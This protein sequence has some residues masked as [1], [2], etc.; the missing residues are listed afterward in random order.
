M[1]SELRDRICLITGGTEGVGKVTALELA[2]KGFTIV[3]KR[4]QGGGAQV[5]WQRI[6]E[7]ARRDAS[8]R[9]F[10]HECS[11]PGL[12]GGG[13]LRQ[14]EGGGPH[15]ALIELRR[16]LE[17][18]RRVSRLKLLTA[19][20]EADYLAVLGIRGHPVPGSRR[21]GWRAGLDDGMD[22]LRHRAIWL[23]HLSD[24]REHVAFPLRLVRARAAARGN[25]PL[26][27]SFFH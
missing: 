20:E 4:C 12:N 22:P 5:V 23:G 15:G 8:A 24:L 16:V 27:E 6:K 11:D 10:L 21:E 18:E 9:C 14:S 7:R 25:L 17:A 2:K 1:R 3:E 26:A 19:L 13:Q